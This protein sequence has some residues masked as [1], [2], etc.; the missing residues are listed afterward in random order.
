[1]LNLNPKILGIIGF[2]LLFGLA[3]ALPPS[4]ALADERDIQ[5]PDIG[6]PASKVLSLAEEQELGTIILGQIRSSLDVINDPELYTYIQSLGTRLV[7]AGIDA[8]LNFTFLIIVSPA[9][10]AFA[11]PGGVIA[12]N[13]GLIQATEN[14]SEL[15]GVMAHEIAH[16]KQRHLAR[17]YANATQVSVATALGV[18]AGIAATAFG[19]PEVGSAAL[20]SAIA[21]GA[22]SQLTF[23]RTNEQEADRIGMEL[24][25]NA[26]YDPDGMPRFFER[27]HKRTQLNAGPVLEFLS[28]HPV[29]LSRISDT[30]NRASQYTGEFVEDSPKFQYAKAR[31]LGLTASPH[32]IVNAYDRNIGDNAPHPTESYNYALALMRLGKARQAIKVLQMLKERGNEPVLI[33][34][35]LAQAHSGA[36]N[37][38][39]AISILQRLNQ[40]YPNHESIV[41]YLA[42]NLIDIGKPMEALRTLENPIR[43]GHHNPLLDSLK[44]RAAAEAKLPWIS[45][46]AMAE[47]YIEYGQYGAAMD[48]FELA[49]REPNIDSVT[50]ARVRSKRKNLQRLKD[51]R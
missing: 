18:L 6:D 46:E 42:Q 33:E 35:A 37:Y 22:Q 23:T 49:L 43:D 32:S 26:T 17:A 10:N 51:E 24:L 15:A 5:L 7:T 25:A 38:A 47:Y 28:T 13:T 1:M 48:Q 44:A 20:H 29:T 41:Y 34:L 16:V 4:S 27:L 12:V 36:N 11:T 30:R 8:D 9:I 3:H 19:S 14:E 31:L 40:V 45:H 39:K 21:A 2:T 50:Q